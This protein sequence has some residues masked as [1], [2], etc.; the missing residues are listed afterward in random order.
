MLSTQVLEHVDDPDRY[1][2]ECYRVLKHKQFLI[3]STHGY[4]LY[5]PHPTDLWRWTGPGLRK[6]IE[7]SGFQILQCEGLMGVAS[8]G[9]HLLQDGINRRLPGPARPLFS[10]IAQI[11]VALCDKLSLPAERT[12]DACVFV[13][14]ATK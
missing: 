9:A 10:F 8:S 1:L 13:I 11:I 12:N 3:L 6:I 4:W 2:K 14:V 5:H 7:R